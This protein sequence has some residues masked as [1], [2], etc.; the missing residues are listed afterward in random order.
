MSNRTP[1]YFLEHYYSNHYKWENSFKK[2]YNLNIGANYDLPYRKLKLGA[3]YSIT[4][5]Y[6]FFNEQALPEQASSEFSVIQLFLRKDFKFGGMNFQNSAMFQEASTNRYVQLPQMI[7]KN[8][9]FYEGVLSKV[10]FYQLGFDFRYETNYYADY[11]SPATGMFYL[12][13]TEKIGN[14]PWIDAFVNFRL[15]RTR[16][17]VK[18]TNMATMFMNG[19]Y[20]T[21]P[22]YPAQVAAASFGLS[23]S[24][25]D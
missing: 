23:W 18:Y 16:F 1:D 21:S 15:K 3:N 11:Y 6:V 22:N 13:Q 12:Q 19:G 14:Y 4:N 24:F 8:S 5:N 10:L 17:Y 25:Y 20:W 7:L 9:S 2:I